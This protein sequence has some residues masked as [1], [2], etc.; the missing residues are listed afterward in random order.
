[1]NAHTPLIRYFTRMDL[2][3]IKRGASGLFELNEPRDYIY[4][5]FDIQYISMGQN[6]I[7]LLRIH[8]AVSG[9]PNTAVHGR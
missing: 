9:E 5:N 4:P 7:F 1:M 3:F 6:I 8:S 2:L